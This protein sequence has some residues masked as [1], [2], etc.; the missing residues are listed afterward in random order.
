[1]GYNPTVDYGKHPVS[2]LVQLDA[3]KPSPEQIAGFIRERFQKICSR[4][5]AFTPLQRGLANPR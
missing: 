4:S 3:V 5:A 1:M 2:R